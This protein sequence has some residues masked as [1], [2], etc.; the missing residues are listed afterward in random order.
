M[1][2]PIFSFKLLLNVDGILMMEYLLLSLQ[3]SEMKIFIEFREWWWY[4]DL[5]FLVLIL[6][7]RMLSY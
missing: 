4:E 1:H 2:L 7:I 5:F 6:E 3:S